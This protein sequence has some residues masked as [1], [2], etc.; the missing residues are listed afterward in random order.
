MRIAHIH[1][2]LIGAI[3]DCYLPKAKDEEWLQA[4]IAAFAEAC[5]EAVLQKA[6]WI[7]LTGN[8]FA[9]GYVT[10]AI[11]SKILDILRETALCFVWREDAIGSAYLRHKSELPPHFYRLSHGKRE[12]FLLREA[13]ISCS[14]L[15][16]LSR[17]TSVLLFEE[18]EKLEEE[19]LLTLKENF[20][21]L[22]YVITPTKHYIWKEGS[23]VGEELVKLE[24]TDFEDENGS[25]Y[26]LL[27]LQEERGESVPFQKIERATYHFRTLRVEVESEDDTTAVYRKCTLA[28]RGL[29]KRD[30]VRIELQGLT[31][32]ERFLNPNLIQER[33]EDR[34]FYLELF[35][36]CKLELDE[37]AYAN[38]ISL[39]SEFVRSVLA[40]DSLS[41][42]EKGRILPCGF[43][44]LEG[45]EV[46]E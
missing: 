18:A 1:A 26:Y 4:R 14:S 5:K 23:F 13:L 22:Q 9:E 16:S 6:E 15:S 44:A 20:P 35:N 45:E 24:G 27:D 43:H 19:T 2:P 10:D 38:D 31:A 41:E 39:K 36:N 8:L 46:S 7:L 40:A 21:R 37:A 17:D 30:F 34:F 32:V 33:L 28:T 11:V 25:G 42:A 12:E 29:G 3:P